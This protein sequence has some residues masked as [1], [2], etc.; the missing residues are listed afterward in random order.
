MAIGR[1]YTISFSKISVSSVQDLWNVAATSSMA[2]ELHSINL[3]AE[4]VSAAEEVTISISRLTATVTNGTGGSSVTPAS[5]SPTQTGAT[6]TARR[7]D[8]TTRAS[9]SGS[10]TNLFYDTWQLTNGYI[11][12]WAPEDRLQFSL[13]QNMIIGLETAPAASHNVSGSITVAELI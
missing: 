12:Q 13:S 2:F 5:I 11:Y 10:T 9:T 1:I 7:N 3:G 8:S 4:G 6:V